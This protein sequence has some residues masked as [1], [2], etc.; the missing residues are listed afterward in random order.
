[1]VR[2]YDQAK[3]KIE[4]GLKAQMRLMQGP[5]KPVGPKLATA[6]RA[7]ARGSPARNSRNVGL[8]FTGFGQAGGPSALLGCS[9]PGVNGKFTLRIDPDAK[10]YFVPVK[11]GLPWTIRD[12]KP[13]ETPIEPSVHEPLY[14]SPDALSPK[15]LEIR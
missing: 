4:D 13:S 12:T 8:S 2:H 5:T 11:H 6:D 10:P 7:R 3:G 15:R 14:S 1:M 9:L